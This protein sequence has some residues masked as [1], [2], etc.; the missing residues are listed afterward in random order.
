MCVE[1]RGGEAGIRRGCAALLLLW[2][3][4]SWLLA[5]PVAAQGQAPDLPT[6]TGWVREAFAAARALS[7]PE[8]PWLYSGV[9]KM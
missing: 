7:A 3:L 5:A 6:Y 9:T 1:Q 2:P 4:V 8:V